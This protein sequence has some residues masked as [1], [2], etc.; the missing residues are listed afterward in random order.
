MSLEK[1]ETEINLIQQVLAG[2]FDMSV[3]NIGKGTQGDHSEVFFGEF[4]GRKVFIK[5][6][7]DTRVFPVEAAGY[8][9]FRQHGIPC[10]EILAQK[11]RT[12]YLNRSVLVETA[13]PGKRLK[14]LTETQ[15]VSPL[16]EAAGRTMAK[17]HQIKVEGF[18]TLRYRGS[19]LRGDC[20]T[21]KENVLGYDRDLG[22]LKANG[23]VDERQLKILTDSIQEIAEVDLPI[24]IFLHNDFHHGHIFSDGKEITGIIDLGAC[25]SGDPRRDL[26]VARFYQTAEEAQ[27]FNRGYG[28]L[29]Y[30]PVV[31]KYL[32]LVAAEKVRYRHKGGFAHRMS[33]ALE[34]L[35]R[36]FAEVQQ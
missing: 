29:A 25:F 16:F 10:P 11:E 34:T 12:G 26:A 32:L 30:D 5:T 7:S 2:E 27:A 22:Y 6:N 36:S 28:P 31:S 4:D 18:G 8:G 14:D 9:L 21:W 13:V 23:F 3:A 33:Q 24:A 15:D 20:E 19:S 17:I 1:E 35:S